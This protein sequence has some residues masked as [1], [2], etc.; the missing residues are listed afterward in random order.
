[1]TL[2]EVRGLTV[3]YGG[4]RANDSIDLDCGE[5]RVVG[6]IGPNGAGK[7]TFIDAITG[8]ARISDGTVVFDG[9]DLS[10]SAPSARARLGL[11]R[12]FQSLEL[13]E[14]LTVGD[15]LL[16][17]AERSHWWSILADVVRPRR[18]DAEVADRV[19]WALDTVG[20]GAVVDVMPD[21]LSHGQRKLVSIA[22]ALAARP[23]L[24]LLDE[25]AA[26]LDPAESRA[27]GVL[28]RT[29]IDEGISLFVIDHDMSLMLSVCDD[30]YVLDFGTIIAHGRPEEVRHDP[31]V[32][33]AYLGDPRPPA[34]DPTEG[35]DV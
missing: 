10:R 22:R 25:P 13:F 2:L 21:Q 8:F 12:T 24:L 3:S 19:A 9:T 11:T 28:M 16:A 34:P 15:N 7:T 30:L 14:D 35:S 26:G 33:A 17:S 1:M 27:L 18:R 6:L 32:I 29:V 4:I 23:K 31:A 5:G 20:L